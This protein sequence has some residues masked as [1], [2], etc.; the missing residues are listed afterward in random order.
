MG[1]KSQIGGIL[2]IISGALGVIGGLFTYLLI[3]FFNEI[4]QQDPASFDYTSGELSFLNGIFILGGTIT[5]LLGVLAI[6]GGIFSVRRK[7]W[8]MALT[9][10]IAGIFTFLPLG[11]ASVIL[12]SMGKSEFVQQVT[13]AL[14]IPPQPPV[15]P[16]S[17]PPAPPAAA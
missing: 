16:P 13:P 17:A 11:I 3:P 10:A 1:N 9:G 15:Q 14:T 12:V 6:I 8:G 4:I 5:L 2:T 7:V